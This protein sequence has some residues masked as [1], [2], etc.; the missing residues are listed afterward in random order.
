MEVLEVMDFYLIAILCLL[1]GITFLSVPK[2]SKTKKVENPAYE[3]FRRLLVSDL[4]NEDTK[5]LLGRLLNLNTRGIVQQS[6]VLEHELQYR[7]VS[8]EL[9]ERDQELVERYFRSPTGFKL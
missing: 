9:N 2:I 7:L 6:A 8:G 1:L 4:K 5:A 3:K